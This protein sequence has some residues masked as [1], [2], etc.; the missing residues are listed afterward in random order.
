MI[1]TKFKVPT[2]GYD[3]NRIIRIARILEGIE[4]SYFSFSLPIKMNYKKSQNHVRL[5]ARNWMYSGIYLSV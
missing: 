2:N 3:I 5:L 1:D 4:S